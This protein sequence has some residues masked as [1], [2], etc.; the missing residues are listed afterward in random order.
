MLPDNADEA[1]LANIKIERQRWP[2]EPF[3]PGRSG[4]QFVA[5][6]T[7]L[8]LLILLRRIKHF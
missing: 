7:K 2:A 1:P 4:T 6:V 5:M 8:V 3:I